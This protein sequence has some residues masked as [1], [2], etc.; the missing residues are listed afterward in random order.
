MT[1]QEEKRLEKIREKMSQMKKQE[2]AIVAKDK[3]RERKKRTRRL[4][5]NGALA[6]KYLECEGMETA[7]FENIL[8]NFMQVKVKQF[9][10]HIKE[11]LKNS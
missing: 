5:Q 11:Q 2:Q 3:A 1:E 4:I 9:L 8:K 7:E 10:E 6:E